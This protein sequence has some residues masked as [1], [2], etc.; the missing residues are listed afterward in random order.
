M[1]SG[2]GVA[3]GLGGPACRSDDSAEAAAGGCEGIEDDARRVARRGASEDEQRNEPK[4]N[5]DGG[6]APAPEERAQRLSR[7]HADDP[8]AVAQLGERRLPAR[9]RGNEMQ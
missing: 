8:A 3:L 6:R 9:R 5:K 2:G 4:T 7:G 1:P